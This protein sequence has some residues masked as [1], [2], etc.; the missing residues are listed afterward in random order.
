[1]CYNKFYELENKGDFVCDIYGGYA[2]IR[3]KL[4][5]KLRHP[6]FINYIEE[7][8]IDEEKIALLYG[9]LKGANLHIEQIEHYVV[10]IMLV[11]IALDTHER[12]SNKSGKKQTNR[13]SIAS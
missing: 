4:M 2:G 3:E 5:V 7:P 6:Y 13:I 10:T 11:Q 1:M 12:V 8:F 9:A